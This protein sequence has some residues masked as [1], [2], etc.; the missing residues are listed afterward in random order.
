VK[1]EK[2]YDLAKVAAACGS[3]KA[4]VIGPGAGPFQEL[5]PNCEMM[6]NVFL[7][8]SPPQIGTHLAWIGKNDSYV[9]EPWKKS[10]QFAL[11]GN[12]LMTDGKPG[13]PV[14]KIVAKNRIAEDDFVTCIRKRLASKYGDKPIGVGGVFLIKKGKANL[15]IMPDFSEKPLKSAEEVDKWLRYFD[16]DAP[17]TC[18]TVFYSH[19]PGLDLRMDHTHCF[20]EHGQGGHYHYDVTPEE[21]E[22]EAYL[23]LAEQVYRVDKP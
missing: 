5:G 13:T 1:R 22:Y 2:Q 6:A 4:F 11:M 17:L 19:D 8:T 10:T 3:P 16:M 14:I 12:F 21:V 9:S 23:T 18:L 20:S 15:H 7:G